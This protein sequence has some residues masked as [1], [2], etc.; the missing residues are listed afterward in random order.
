[1][2]WFARPA[3]LLL[4]SA[5][6]TAYAENDLNFCHKRSEESVVCSEQQVDGVGEVAA[7]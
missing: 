3:K 2:K 1:M 6:V 5:S 7:L 4:M